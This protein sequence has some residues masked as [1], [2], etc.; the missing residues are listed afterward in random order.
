MRKTGERQRCIVFVCRNGDVFFTKLPVV[1]RCVDLNEKRNQYTSTQ[2]LTKCQI[3]YHATFDI[4]PSN[5]D[6]K[7]KTGV[8]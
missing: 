4:M 1:K 7:I 5:V 8:K 6:S 2:T 3:K